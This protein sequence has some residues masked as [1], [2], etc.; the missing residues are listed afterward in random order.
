MVKDILKK[1]PVESVIYID[2]DNTIIAIDTIE[3]LSINEVERH[4]Y[5]NYKLLKCN[6]YDDNGT[7]CKVEL[8]LYP[9]TFYL[10]VIYTN[11]IYKY[12]VNYY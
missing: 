3:F 8:W 12:K 4:E 5:D 2:Y 11:F 9:K 10:K 7:N 1:L 6:A